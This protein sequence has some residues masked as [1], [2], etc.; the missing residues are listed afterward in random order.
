MLGY[1][2]LFPEAASTMASEVDHLY[3][4]LLAVSAVF[5]IGIFLAVAVFRD[6]LPAAS[7]AGG[8]QADRRLLHPGDN[9]ERNPSRDLD[10]DFRLG[11]TG[12]FR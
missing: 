10:G 6:P 3:F 9:L 2:P 11:S 5:T 8:A 12:V 4:F 7:P 1:L